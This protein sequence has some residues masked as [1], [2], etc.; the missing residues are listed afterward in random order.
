[1]D[2]FV[3]TILSAQPWQFD[4]TQVGMP[5]R[6][7]SVKWKGGSK[8]IIG[9]MWHDGVVKPQPPME[10]ALALSVEKLVKAGYEVKDLAPY[11]S[12]EAWDIIVSVQSLVLN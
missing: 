7:E 3:S 11:R 2:L 12:V 1:M 9:V 5:W 8:P 4:P 10:R 6:P